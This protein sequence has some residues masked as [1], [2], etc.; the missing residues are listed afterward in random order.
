MNVW[1]CVLSSNMITVFVGPCALQNQYELSHLFSGEELTSDII[2]RY[3]NLLKSQY[4]PV[5]GL[6]DPVYGVGYDFSTQRGTFV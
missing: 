5:G 2:A 1:G 6:E 3:Q 4:I